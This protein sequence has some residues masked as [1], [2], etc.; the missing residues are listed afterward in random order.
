MTGETEGAADIQDSA[1]SGEPE[2][3]QQTE[4][5]QASSAAGVY[6][7]SYTVKYGDT[8]ANICRMYYGNVDKL[9]EVCQVNGITDPN[10]IIMGQKIVLP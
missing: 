1:S 9:D 10:T 5:A 8:L 4:A 7:S 2:T 6:Q 3:T